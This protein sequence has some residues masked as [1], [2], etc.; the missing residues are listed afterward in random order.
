[1][2]ADKIKCIHF[3]KESKYPL[4]PTISVLPLCS[5]SLELFQPLST[6]AEAW[7][8]IPG[9]SEWVMAIISQGYTLQF[10]LRPPNFHGVR[11]PSSSPEWVRLLQPLLPRPQKRQ[12][13]ATF[14]RSQT[15]ES[16]P[17]KK[18]VQDDQI[19]ADHPTN[20]PRGLVHVTGSD[21]HL[22]SYPR[23]P[24]HRR[25]LRFAFKGVV[26]QYKVLPF[27]L[28]L[29][30]RTFTR[31]MHAALSPLRQMG[32]RILNYLN[33]WLILAQ[34]EAVSTSQKTLLLS[35]LCCLG[36]RVNFTKSASSRSASACWRM[37]F[38]SG[39]RQIC[40]HW[41][42]RMCREKWTKEQTC[43]QETMSPQRNG[44]S[45]LLSVKKIWEV[46]GRAQVDLFA[47]ECL[48]YFSC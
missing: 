27:G 16:R 8:A 7:Q 6:W 19:E 5:Q 1:M 40:A 18:V 17:G 9:V 29:A 24:H 28:S 32:I 12:W 37:T 15:P 14:S 35:H 25:F 36:L 34:S 13:P 42:R 48:R 44:C 23:S 3:Q 46:F 2:I 26:Y 45:T 22:L 41:G 21:R 47:R 33:D 30:P 38:L 20:I 4:L 39:L 11:N 43:C 31:C 10:A